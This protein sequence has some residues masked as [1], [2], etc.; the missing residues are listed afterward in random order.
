MLAKIQDKFPIAS[1]AKKLLRRRIGAHARVHVHFLRK[2]FM[3]LDWCC[4]HQHTHLRTRSLQGVHMRSCMC[5]LFIQRWGVDLV[6]ES[7]CCLAWG[8]IFD[9]RRDR[10]VAC[11]FS[12]FNVGGSVCG[13]RCVYTHTHPHTAHMRHSDVSPGVRM[14]H[15]EGL[16]NPDG[17]NLGIYV[18]V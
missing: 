17:L 9:R 8:V 15:L 4:E 10:G 13:C 5:S 12:I 18:I 3:P 6:Y 7:T 16:K 11:V 1:M 2:V 14:R